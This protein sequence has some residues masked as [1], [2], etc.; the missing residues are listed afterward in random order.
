[1]KMYILHKIVCSLSL[2]L[3]AVQPTPLSAE[4]LHEKLHA[5]VD[6]M[7]TAIRQELH[8]ARAAMATE[9]PHRAGRTPANAV[10]IERERALKTAHNARARVN[11]LDADVQTNLI[12][13]QEALNVMKSRY[14]QAKKDEQE[15]LLLKKEIALL[16]NRLCA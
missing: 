4:T 10:K 8:K 3:L 2:A 14:A 11:E 15:I 16:E 1:M 13:A 12:D 5:T 9:T 7:A 6:T